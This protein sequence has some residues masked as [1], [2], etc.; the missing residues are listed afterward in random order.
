MSKITNDSLTRS[1]TKCFMA[2]PI[3]HWQTV[4][5]KWSTLHFT[6]LH[7]FSRRRVIQ[8]DSTL[9][10]TPSPVHSSLHHDRPTSNDWPQSDHDWPPRCPAPVDGQL[11]CMRHSRHDTAPSNYQRATATDAAGWVP[12]AAPASAEA[13]LQEV[14]LDDWSRTVWGSIDCVTLGWVVCR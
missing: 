13:R 7:S 11:V 8:L 3:W 9:A 4:G 12:T 6:F 1:G 10:F 5:V 2:V 14:G